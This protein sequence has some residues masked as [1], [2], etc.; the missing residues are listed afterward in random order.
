MS[1]FAPYTGSYDKCKIVYAGFA[2]MSH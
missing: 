2:V 1:M